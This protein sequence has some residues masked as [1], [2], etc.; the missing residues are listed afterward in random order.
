MF[1]SLRNLLR[2]KRLYD[3]LTEG[4]RH[5]AL[6][7]SPIYHRKLAEAAAA[8]TEVRLMLGFLKNYKT[9]LAGLAAIFG[10]AAAIAG[11]PTQAGDP[12]ILSTILAGIGLLF[13]KDSNVT[14]G[15]KPQTPEAEKRTG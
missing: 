13:A 6:W 10:A 8:V 15:T 3:V 7:Q 2:I 5:R 4:R 12:G 1:G 14:G 9:T 11:D